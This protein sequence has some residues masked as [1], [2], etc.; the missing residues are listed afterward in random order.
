MLT[1]VFIL[2]Q[3][4]HFV[5]PPLP[6]ARGWLKAGKEPMTLDGSFVMPRS[7]KYTLRYENIHAGPYDGKTVLAIPQF[8]DNAE[9]KGNQLPIYDIDESY[10]HITVKGKPGS[11]W[12]YHLY[13]AVPKEEHAK[14]TP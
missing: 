4:S 14:T 2:A 12:W 6:A 11:T 9:C 3:L 5:R 8:C 10:D 7:G 13:L 1:L